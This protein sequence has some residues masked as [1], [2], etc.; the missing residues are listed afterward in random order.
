MWMLRAADRPVTVVIYLGPLRPPRN[1]DREVGSETKTDRRAQT[2]WPRFN[3][4]ERGLRPIHLPDQFSH[5]TAPSQPSG[6]ARHFYS[7]SL[8]AHSISPSSP[9][10]YSGIMM[11][12]C[13]PRFVY[14]R[15]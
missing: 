7:L 3:R 5:L 15:F 12:T 11:F 6:G 9:P 13:K 8:A 14:A 2:L 1:R 4:P 10:V